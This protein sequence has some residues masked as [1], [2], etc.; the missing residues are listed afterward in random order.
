MSDEAEGG[1]TERFDGAWYLLVELDV[2]KDVG[3]GG[4][5]GGEAIGKL[6]DVILGVVDNVVANDGG[7]GGAGGMFDDVVSNDDGIGGAGGIFDVL[8]EA[9]GGRDDAPIKKDHWL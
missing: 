8:V 2:V 5:I 7:I 3:I 9:N 6:E 1:G 4:A